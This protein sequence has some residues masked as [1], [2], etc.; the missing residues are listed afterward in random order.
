[1]NLIKLITIFIFIV[2][3]SCVYRNFVDIKYS[4]ATLMVIPWVYFIF[5]MLAF[6]NFESGELVSKL[7]VYLLALL[8]TY[9][10]IKKDAIN[11]LNKDVN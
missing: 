7:A 3:L 9:V 6:Y 2:S 10:Y 11:L 5:S 4:L 1:M 8:I